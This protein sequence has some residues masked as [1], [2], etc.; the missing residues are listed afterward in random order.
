MSGKERRFGS[1][2]WGRIRDSRVLFLQCVPLYLAVAVLAV[3]TLLD[4]VEVLVSLVLLA[5]LILGSIPAA[6]VASGISLRPDETLSRGRRTLTIAAIA[7][8]LAACILL[9][10]AG[11]T[12]GNG[13]QA[14]LGLAL[15]GISGI[16]PL[17]SALTRLRRHGG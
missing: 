11:F 13:L 14:V 17:G 4:A 6:I 10:V 3:I 2:Y 5:L 1:E 9:V 8:F 16:P 15:L 7:P 12:I